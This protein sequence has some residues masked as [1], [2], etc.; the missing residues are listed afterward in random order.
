MTRLG[1]LAAS[2]SLAVALSVPLVG[3]ATAAPAAPVTTAAKPSAQATFA[4]KTHTLVNAQRTKHDV[5][6]LKKNACLTKSAQRQA[7]RMADQGELF[8]QDLGK[9]LDACGLNAAGENVAYGYPTPARTVAGW[10]GSAGHRANIL[11]GTYRLSGVGAV[12][13]DGRWYVAQVFGRKA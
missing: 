13:K 7:R 12:K 11:S 9:V 6:A 1:T 8:H 2:A 10:M 5:R 4:T 3:A